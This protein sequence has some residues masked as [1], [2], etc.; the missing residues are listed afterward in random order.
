MSK[1][2]QLSFDVHTMYL[3]LGPWRFGIP[4]KK[5]GKPLSQV[6]PT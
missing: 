5:D 3:G 6:T 2:K 1:G 4:L